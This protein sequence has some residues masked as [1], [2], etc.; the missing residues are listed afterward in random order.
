MQQFAECLLKFKECISRHEWYSVKTMNFHMIIFVSSF[1]SIATFHI[2]DLN[3]S[4]KVKLSDDHSNQGLIN[5]A[6]V[7]NWQQSLNVGSVSLGSCLLLMLVGLVLYL[8][9]D[10]RIAHSEAQ[11]FKLTKEISSIQD[12]KKS[13]L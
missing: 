1:L 3:I 9:L 5:S 4:S 13:V 8:R 11:L 6:I 2:P 12:A 10:D 7:N